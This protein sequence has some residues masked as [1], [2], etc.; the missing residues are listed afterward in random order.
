MPYRVCLLVGLLCLLI[1]GRIDAAERPYLFKADEAR[2]RAL[3]AAG[4]AK[5]ANFLYW[6]DAVAADRASFAFTP[7]WWLAMAAWL[8]DDAD[9][10]RL[11]HD[12][13]MA[14]VNAHPG[15]DSGTGDI[16]LH[17]HDRMLGI[18]ACV[19]LMY[20]S[21][22]SAERSAIADWVNGT[23]DNWNEQNL[24]FWPYDDPLN[25]YWQNGFLGHVIA[26]IC[27]RGFNPRADEWRT[28]AQTMYLK[29]QAACNPP[30]WNGPVLAEGNGY[31]NFVDNALWAM[32]LHD[33]SLGTKWFADSQVDCDRYLDLLR[34][35]TRPEPSLFF[36]VGSQPGAPWAPV[37]TVSSTYW[38]HLIAKAGDTP[39]ARYA[40]AVLEAGLPGY[41]AERDRT[42]AEFYW[43]TSAVATV[44]LAAIPDRM[45]VTPA[46]GAG[47]IGLRSAAGFQPGAIAAL[48]FSNISGGGGI[49]GGPA[50]FSHAHP[51]AP[52]F[53]WARGADWLVADPDAFTHSGIAAETLGSDFSNIVT[54]AGEP[55]ARAESMFPVATFCEDNT[56]GAVP[57][58]YL[59]IDAQPFWAGASTYRRDYVWLDDLRVVAVFDHVVGPQEKTWRLH[60]PGAVA[61][62]GTTADYA[63]GGSS[64][65]V[66]DL[67]ASGGAAWT[68][69]S[70]KDEGSAVG[71][72]WR[73]SQTSTASDYRSLKILDVDGRV[74][75]AALTTGV[76]WYQAD[77]VI[78]GL[79]RSL[80]F[81]DD[82]T[83]MALAG[84]G[85]DTVPPTIS[86]VAAEAGPTG[87]AITWTTNEPTDARVEY[88]PTSAYGTS[89]A[90]EAALTGAH[91]I[92]LSG[93]TPTTTYHYRVLSR[94][95]SG[96]A[97][98]SADATFTTTSAAQ[99][100]SPDQND[101]GDAG[102]GAD[103]GSGGCGLGGIA[104]LLCALPAVGLRRRR[105]R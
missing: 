92:D 60:V 48:I 84:D 105:A 43:S 3:I 35:L 47:L 85:D 33:A 45:N 14:E 81:Y 75:S 61:I 8:E 1:A 72:V 52:G 36:H 97:A 22:T 30:V 71:D 18:P 39:S 68:E 17:V 16:F 94:D 93:L 78:D 10:K 80:R 101:G 91:R 13:V 32:D 38:H 74:A 54:L 99:P 58:F 28:K 88:G 70:L 41:Q 83:H 5:A 31:S 57:H 67:F 46:P 59:Q 98:A 7:G 100:A 66:R 50:R 9:M 77:L 104:L 69:A 86:A 63:A 55:N 2:L 34:F 82:G 53:Q 4:D 11:V 65:R 23:L 29:F 90:L 87:A 49:S 21:F 44:P 96:N 73:L 26:G 19:D 62:T 89:S 15:G 64:V 24:A 76:G 95:V 103:G 42:F 79:S 37:T 27:T 6:M 51:D 20:G 40:K 12:E 25:N 102:S 56:A